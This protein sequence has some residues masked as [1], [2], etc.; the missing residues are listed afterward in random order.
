[1]KYVIVQ[2]D[3]M[4]DHPQKE[5][6]GR[7]PLEAANTPNMDTIAS[8]GALG[9]V[10]TIPGDLPP[11]SSVGNMSLMGLN[12]KKYYTGRAPLEAKGLG[13]DLGEKDIAFRCNLV[14]FGEN[15]SGRI[16]KD[17]SGGHP[18]QESARRYIQSVNE[19]L[20]GE[21]FNFYPGVSYR[22]LLI[23]QDGRKKI[24]HEEISLTPPHDITGESL[25]RYLPRGP[26]SKV[27]LELQNKATDLL[28][29]SEGALNGVWFWGAGVKPEIPTFRSRYGLQGH[30]ISA[31]DLING[32]G[33][34]SG[35]SPVDVEG[36]T[37]L[38]D[39]NYEGKVDAVQDNL[40]DDS[41]VYLHIEAPDEAAHAGDLEQKIEAIERIDRKVLA[42][43]LEFL[44]EE[45]GVRLL[46]VT[47]HITGVESKTH[48]RGPVPFA[49]FENPDSRVEH[50]SIFSEKSAAGTGKDFP[51]GQ[52]LIDFFLTEG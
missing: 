30:V 41:L 32:L 43:L 52:E 1:M 20:G 15:G 10:N 51:G 27:L 12:P 42:P 40:A 25:E 26:G 9:T 18:S 2:G 29:G 8:A 13:V 11:G 50:Q 14:R 47:D 17:Y 5:L 35:L 16:M 33:A 6:S 19:E 44:Q 24:N 4:A 49:V 46:L 7:T 39:T 28:R 37:G 34:Y 31:V 21:E 22:N 48:E 36:A 45:N 23:W 38:I 3:G